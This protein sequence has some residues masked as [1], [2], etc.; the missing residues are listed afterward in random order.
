MEQMVNQVVKVSML[1]FTPN[2]HCVQLVPGSIKKTPARGFTLIEMMVVV[3]LMGLVAS[4]AL[5]NFER[6]FAST[7]QRVDASRIALQVQNLLARAAILNQSIE[8]T[9]DNHQQLL[10]DGKPALDLPLGWTLQQPSL[11][12]VNGSG[13][14]VPAEI[15]FVSGKQEYIVVQ[16]RNHKCSVGF[17]LHRNAV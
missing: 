8:L 15:T 16:V 13:Y 11:L 1:T 17:S 7:Q 4:V 2:N 3:V 9:A 14:C 6:W 10:V 5:P 12:V